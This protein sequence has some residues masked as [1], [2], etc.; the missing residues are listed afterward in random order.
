[1]SHPALNMVDGGEAWWQSPPLSRGRQYE[2]VNVTIY[3]G[4]VYKC[5]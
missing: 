3:L 5:N 2:E 4:Q 1:M